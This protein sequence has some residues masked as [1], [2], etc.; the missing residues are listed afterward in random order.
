MRLLLHTPTKTIL[1]RY[2]AAINDLSRMFARLR[3][4]PIWRGKSVRYY[5]RLI[6]DI[7]LFR[8]GTFVLYAAP[9]SRYYATPLIIAQTRRHEGLRLIQSPSQA[10]KRCPSSVEHYRCSDKSGTRQSRVHVPDP[11][12]AV[13]Y[14]PVAAGPRGQ[15]GRVRVAV[16]VGGV[17]DPG[18]LVALLG[19]A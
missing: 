16:A 14:L 10:F 6:V 1:I 15:G 3:D 12:K 4:I 9:D 18:G 7:Q 19:P 5:R 13:F 17:G 2:L 11:V 8:L